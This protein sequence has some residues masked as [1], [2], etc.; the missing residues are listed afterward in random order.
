MR[1]ETGRTYASIS[2]GKLTLLFTAD[3]LPA[4]ADVS[5][6]HAHHFVLQV[7][8]V[9]D[10]APPPAV[11]DLFD[12]VA[13]ST[14]PPPPPPPVDIFRDDLRAQLDKVKQ[15]VAIDSDVRDLFDRIAVYLKVA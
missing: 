6:N 13:F 2:Q 10:L 5:E 12:G 9:T 14:P 3:D 1:A 8:D 15:K 7:I 11:G 4:W